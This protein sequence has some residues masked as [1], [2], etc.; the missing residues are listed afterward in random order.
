MFLISFVPLWEHRATSK[1]NIQNWIFMS[2][3]PN[4]F[5]FASYIYVNF[6]LLFLQFQQF[7]KKTFKKAQWNLSSAEQLCDNTYLQQIAVISWKPLVFT[8]IF[9]KAFQKY[10]IK[11]IYF[12]QKKFDEW[13]SS[14]Y[15][16]G[17]GGRKGNLKKY[18]GIKADC[19]FA[20]SI[21]EIACQSVSMEGNFWEWSFF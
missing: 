14:V 7:H 13:I 4:R 17:F 11:R 18:Q 5:I 9:R 19:K 10:V 16:R 3:N 21:I 6:I 8:V 15:Y 1:C 2:G 20:F 12:N